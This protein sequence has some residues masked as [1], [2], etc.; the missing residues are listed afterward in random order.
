LCVLASG[1]RIPRPE[2]A[3][4]TQE[5]S[6]RILE[7]WPAHSAQ[8]Y[9]L[10]TCCWFNPT[11]CVPPFANNIIPQIQD[12]MTQVAHDGVHGDCYYAV[13]DLI[14]YFCAPNTKTF[15]E[16]DINSPTLH[17]CFDW[18]SKLFDACKDQFKQLAPSMPTPKDPEQLCDELFAFE[19]SEEHEN[20][21]KVD[22]AKGTDNCFKGVPLSTVEA[23]GCLPDHSDHPKSKGGLS[24]TELVSMIL[25][26]IFVLCMAGGG[27]GAVFLWFRI[28]SQNQPGRS[29]FSIPVS[30]FE[31]KAKAQT[32]ADGLGDDDALLLDS[33]DLVEEEKGEE[34]K[35]EEEKEGTIN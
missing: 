27:V 32:P 2:T 12:F 3:S 6:S 28:R 29:V 8:S 5:K 34:E 33:S 9:K 4:L 31:K 1:L 23:A 13:A 22:I 15:M 18:C 24:S 16:G 30:A 7:C 17:I 10:E 26:P 21:I 11:C 20:Q 25:I 14:C 19:E 35:G